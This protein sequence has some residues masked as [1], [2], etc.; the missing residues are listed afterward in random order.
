METKASSNN[1][2]PALTP[3]TVIIL[4]PFIYVVSTHPR[5]VRNAYNFDVTIN[6]SGR[7][8]FY[9]LERNITLT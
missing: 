4:Q 8:G 6:D 5:K 7:N 2:P 1:E 9:I 3:E